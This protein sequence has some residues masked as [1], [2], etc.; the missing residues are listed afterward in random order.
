MVIMGRGIDRTCMLY[1]EEHKTTRHGLCEGRAIAKL[2]YQ[3]FG[4]SFPK[5]SAIPAIDPKEIIRFTQG[6]QKT[7][8][9]LFGVVW[10]PL[11][12]I[13]DKEA[14]SPEI[15]VSTQLSNKNLLLVL[16]YSQLPLTKHI[17]NNTTFNYKA[18]KRLDHNY[19]IKFKVLPRTT[20]YHTNCMANKSLFK[21]YIH[22]YDIGMII[23]IQLINSLII[24]ISTQKLIEYREKHTCDYLGAQKRTNISEETNNI[25]IICK[26]SQHKTIMLIKSSV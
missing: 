12:L 7:F 3:H 22:N 5:P 1:L 9:V 26:I 17:T 20:Q 4:D 2:R 8:Q 18:H 21:M 23:K 25:Q 13:M 6:A 14:S 24:I 19:T 11:S 15:A 16:I 10:F